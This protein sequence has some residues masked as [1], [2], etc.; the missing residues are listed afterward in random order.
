MCDRSWV[1][2]YGRRRRRKIG[3][4]NVW[5]RNLGGI[6]HL[7]LFSN[8]SMCSE[9]R[10]RSSKCERGCALGGIPPKENKAGVV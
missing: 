2:A 5:V 6:S 8:S 3:E 4:Y 1:C 7:R 10:K 9:Q